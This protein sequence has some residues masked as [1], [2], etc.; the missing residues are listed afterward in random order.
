M[1]VFVFDRL[2]YGRHLDHLKV[3]AGLPYPL[4]TARFEV[5]TAQGGGMTGR[6]NR[7]EAPLQRTR[8][9][10]RLIDATSE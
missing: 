1:E 4:G 6:T 10:K 3:G 5:V 9:A 8:V 7:I 2:A